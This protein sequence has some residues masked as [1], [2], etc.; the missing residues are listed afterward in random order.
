MHDEGFRALEDNGMKNRDVD[1]QKRI[2]AEMERREMTMGVFVA[3][4]EFG[5]VTFASDDPAV[6][7]AIR[8]DMEKAVEVAKRRE[9]PLVHGRA[10]ARSRARLQPDY[11][12]AH[13]IDNLRRA[14][15]ICEKAGLVMVLEPLNP[16]R[17]H[18]GLFLTKIPQAYLVC[19][20]VDSPSCKILDDPLPPAG[21]RG[22][23]HPQLRTRVVG[24]R[25]L[26]GRGPPGAQGAGDRRDQLPQRLRAD[27]RARL[28]RRG[29]DGAR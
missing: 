3:H 28:P 26:P 17:D 4:A 13:V 14:A 11:Q 9:R 16:W 15:E 1:L 8:K 6:R 29:R 19:R 5:R 22:G 2:A 25:L 20:G 10:G 21:D 27:P 23:S 12:T 18:P 7:D 24:D